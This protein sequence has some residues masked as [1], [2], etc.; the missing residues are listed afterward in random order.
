VVKVN[1]GYALAATAWL[2]LVVVGAV[3]VWAVISRAGQGVVAQQNPSLGEVAPFTSPA[4]AKQQDRPK[5]DKPSPKPPAKSDSP[6]PGPPSGGG[7][8]GPRPPAGTN[9]PDPGPSTTPSPDPG[10]GPGPGPK[11]GP[12]PAP[13]PNNPPP[14][15]SPP[16]QPPPE[17]QGVRRTWQGTSGS[18]T[19]ECRGSRIELMGAQPNSGWRIEI[20]SR[21]PEEVR[22]E[23]DSTNGD[24]RT[25]VQSV[26][27]GGSPRFEI[28]RE[29]D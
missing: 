28:D 7:T 2:V 4:Q 12:G 21:G 20:D 16:P 22:V 14:S 8:S 11:P 25:R 26:C 6:P 18:V 17:Q 19:V 15:S 10:P 1:R 24:R 5:K 3:L 23:F 29:D 27:V 9:S 13:S